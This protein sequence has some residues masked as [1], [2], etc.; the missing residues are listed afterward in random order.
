M[1]RL[2]RPSA[3]SAALRLLP[4]P[5][6]TALVGRLV[7]EGFTRDLRQD[8]AVWENKRYIDPP[9][10]AEGDGPIGRYRRWCRQFYGQLPGGEA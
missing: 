10:L 7:F 8:F 5:L 9:G 1:K 6:A 2:E 4:A 3:V